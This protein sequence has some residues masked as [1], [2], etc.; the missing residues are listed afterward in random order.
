MITYQLDKNFIFTGENPNSAEKPHLSVVVAPPDIPSGK[1]ARW[2]TTLDPVGDLAFGDPDTGN[3]KIA[4]DNRGKKLYS[5]ITGNEIVDSDYNGIDE[6]P[7]DTTLLKPEHPEMQWDGEKWTFSQDVKARLDKEAVEQ[8]RSQKLQEINANAQA[9]INQMTGLDKVPDFEV[10]TWPLQAAEAKAWASDKTAQTPTLDNIAA[11]R[12][13]ERITLIEKALQKAVAYE[14]LVA[15]IAGQR[16]AYEDALKA[17]TDNDAIDA[18]NPM[19]KLPEA[20]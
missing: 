15:H 8:A 11:S 9:F 13:M 19:Y 4:D 14:T 5:T 1:V 2:V 6:L 16:Q 18:I 17:A 12:S 7:I 10:A 20:V 3:W